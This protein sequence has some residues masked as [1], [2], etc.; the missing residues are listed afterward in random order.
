MRFKILTGKIALGA[1][2]PNDYTDW[3]MA[4]LDSGSDSENIAILASL[5]LE[6]N[7]DSEEVKNY[8]Y[9]SLNDLGIELPTQENSILSYAKYICA[10]IIAGNISPMK[11]LSVL[12]GIYSLSDYEPIYSIWDELSEDIWMV[13]EGEGCF[14][15]TSLTK[16]NIDQ[17]I[18]NVAEQFIRL[19]EIEL[20]QYFFSLTVC[21]KCGYIGEQE[22]ERIDK[23]WLHEKIF[24]MLYKRGPTM[25]A[26][27]SQCGEPFP[28]GMEDYLGREQYLKSRC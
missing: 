15:N 27:C 2:F 18:I 12:D 9:R 20:P 7:P 13:N 10:E 24:R 6:K 19:T 11:G 25:N 3:A 28:L 21:Q 22:M 14:F 23:P 1:A 26:I 8:F 16:E 17:F 4:M 5:G